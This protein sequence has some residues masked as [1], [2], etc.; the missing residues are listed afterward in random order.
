M[1]L[2][3]I[4]GAISELKNISTKCPKQISK[5][6]ETVIELTIRFIQQPRVARRNLGVGFSQS[7]SL[8]SA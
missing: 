5:P 3:R 2:E 4:G 7:L 8:K 1:G 6:V